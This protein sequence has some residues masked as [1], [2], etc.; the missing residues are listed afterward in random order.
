MSIGSILVGVAV[1]VIVGAYLARPF[2]IV[3]VGA[4][5]DRDIETWVSLVQVEDPVTGAA[6]IDL[7]EEAD[8]LEEIDPLEDVDLLE[9]ADSES[10]NFCSRCGRHLNADDRFCPGCGT[11]VKRGTAQ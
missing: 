5:L 3:T 10:V 7:L 9:D 2:R 1:V 6:E 4:D 8:L 11:Q